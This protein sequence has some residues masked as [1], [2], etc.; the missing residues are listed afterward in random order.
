MV[1]HIYIF[2]LS[3]LHTNSNANMILDGQSDGERNTKHPIKRKEERACRGGRSASSALLDPRGSN[4]QGIQL[5]VVVI[6][7]SS[8]V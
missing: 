3:K 2:G 5:E 8:A 7:D 4:L 1:P 6:R